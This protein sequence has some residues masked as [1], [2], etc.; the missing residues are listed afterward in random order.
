MNRLFRRGARRW[1]AL[2]LLA[3]FGAICLVASAHAAAGAPMAGE[4][5]PPS[6]SSYGDAGQPLWTQ[7]AGRARQEPFNVIATLIFVLAIVH[8]FLAAKFQQ[9]AH[10]VEERHLLRLAAARGAEAIAGA[11]EPVCFAAVVLHFLGEVEAIFGIWCVPLLLAIVLYYGAKDGLGVGWSR[12]AHYLGSRSFDEPLFVFV[13]MAEAAARPVVKL[14]GDILRALARLGRESPAAW[15]A[16]ILTVAPLLGSFITEPA[17]M[18]IAALLLSREFFPLNPSRRLKYATLGLLFVNVSA[19]GVLTHFAAPPVIMVAGKWGWTTPYM[20]E[21]FGLEAMI[22]IVLSNAFYFLVFRREFAALGAAQR[23]TPRTATPE[24]PVPWWV[25]LAHLLALA[26][27]VVSLHH[28][29]LL[30]AGFLFFLAFLQAT[31]HHQS[32]L[33]LRGPVMVGFFLAGLVVHGGLQSWWI[34]PVLG[35]LGEFTLFLGAVGLT[36][37][38]DNAAITYLATFSPEIAGASALQHAVMQGAL[39]G[40]GL[41]VIA[42]APNPAGQSLLAKHFDNGISPLG[43]LLGAAAPTVIV[44]ACFRVLGAIF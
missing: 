14:A 39:T 27:S 3:G 44:G 5:F 16:S 24:V 42:N 2:A 18:T 41:T 30:I 17:A 15:W 11:R 12:A 13:I 19:G 38:N 7:L 6:L 23:G 26:W 20:I 9:W 28:P 36:A 25:T 8:T 22:G 43:L 32:K 1:A 34:A 10:V 21:H 35:S 29:V 33:S 40:G 31:A 4:D 37:F